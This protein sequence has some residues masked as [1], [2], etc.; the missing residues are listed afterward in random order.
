[1]LEFENRIKQVCFTGHRPEKLIRT[2]QDIR[3]DLEKQIYQAVSDGPNVFITGMARGV[4]LW[5]AQ[6]VLKLR[7]E[8]EDVKL[9]CA[10]P[11]DGFESG[12]KEEWQRQYREIL[13]SADSVQYICNSYSR[14]CF[15]IRNRWMVDHAASI[16]AVYNGKKGGTKNTIDYAAKNGIPII[17]IEG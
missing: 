17:C 12:W 6:I 13:A 1:M 5:A 2:E 10:C 4:D 11:Y 16:I 9:L 14:A 15:Q 3:V 7:D 8:N